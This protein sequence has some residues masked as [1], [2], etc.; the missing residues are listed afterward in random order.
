MATA[1]SGKTE[2]AKYL[3]RFLANRSHDTLDHDD[4]A[5]SQHE[6]LVEVQVRA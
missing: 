5:A 4:S 1:G 6:R 2:S 3:M